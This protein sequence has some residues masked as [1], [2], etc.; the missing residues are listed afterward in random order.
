M[1]P[2]LTHTH[3]PAPAQPAAQDP[4]LSQT[5]SA[6]QDSKNNGIITFANVF[7]E[8][9]EA[10]NSLNGTEPDTTLK[11]KNSDDTAVEEPA[12]GAGEAEETQPD[13]LPDTKQARP[14][15]TQTQISVYNDEKQV[16]ALLENRSATVS[17]SIFELSKS[18]AQSPNN[19]LSAA[20]DLGNSQAPASKPALP[21]NPPVHPKMG[22]QSLIATQTQETA[23]GT[24]K[25]EATEILDS[26]P[27]PTEKATDLIR[28]NINTSP[29][30][31]SKSPVPLDQQVAQPDLNAPAPKAKSPPPE[32]EVIVTANQ[33]NSLSSTIVK[34]QMTA[35][36]HVVA[37]P[38]A[39]IDPG[40]RSTFSNRTPPETV[41][42]TPQQV[43]QSAPTSQPQW[44]VV[45]PPALAAQSEAHKVVLSGEADP[46][47]APRFETAGATTPHQHTLPT[48]MD[49][50]HHVARQIADALQHLPNRPVEIVLSPEELGRVRLGVSTSEGNIMVSVLAER[51]E[52]TELIRR[53]IS[54]LE[55]A[56]QELGYSNINFSFTGDR[57]AESSGQ[58]PQKES[59]QGS[60]ASAQDISTDA[61]QLHLRSAPLSGVD[62]RL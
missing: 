56:F 59:G 58:G 27:K 20:S 31:A 37:V 32:Q 14:E 5:P 24:A 7:E 28:G 40:K 33:P 19:V 26:S 25:I 10:A 13:L 17:A 60:L 2:L 45:Q 48:R 43:P 44:S 57:S 51:P 53:H 62:I 55:T 61:T 47:A 21:V 6:K 23:S 54:A 39:A 29:L 11:T 9:A 16:G 4:S 22:A 50:P 35:A 15:K 34:E 52:T 8:A 42:A 18:S 36:A 41:S 30:P 3:S 49:L 46:L 1:H 12:K 38:Q